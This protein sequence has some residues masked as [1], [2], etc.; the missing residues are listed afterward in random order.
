M[1][2]G[3]QQVAQRTGH[4]T[5]LLLTSDEHASYE[6]AIREVYGLT[7]PPPEK[8]GRRRPPKPPRLLP[9]ELC[10]A[11]VKKT[12]RNGRVVDVV[13]TLVFG[14]LAVLDAYLQ[15]SHASRKINTAFVERHN[16]TDRH[17]N[18]RK[19]RKTYSS[20]TLAKNDRGVPAKSRPDG[21]WQLCGYGREQVGLWWLDP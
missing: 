8:P 16:G 17:Q 6:V 11:T 14:I 13:T 15:R 10:Y 9:D 20:S 2:G 5:D 4:R 12:R 21:A 1:F 7:T 18:A 19:R 3:R